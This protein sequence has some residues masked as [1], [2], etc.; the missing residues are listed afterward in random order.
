MGWKDLK[1]GK[2]LAFGF[3]TILILFAVASFLNYNNLTTVSDEMQ[4]S[5][6]ANA[7]KAFSIEK[8]VDHLNWVIGLREIFLN[9]DVR[10]VQ[11]QMDPTQCGLGKWLLSD[12]TKQ[13]AAN[14]P[15]LAQLLKEIEAPHRHL[16]ESAKTIDQ[17]YKNDDVAEAYEVF[18]KETN[19]HLSQTK[20]ILSQLKDHFSDQSKHAEAEMVGQVNSSITMMTAITIVGIIIGALAAY[21]IT[22]GIARPIGRISDVA[23]EIAMGEINHEIEVRSKD[24]VG[25][26]AHAFQN[27]IGYMRNIAQGAEKI[28]NNDLRVE[29]TPKSEND[30]LGNSFKTMSTNLRNIISQLNAGSGELVAAAN[31]IASTSAEMAKGAR[32]QTEQATQIA[33]AIEEMAA[34]IVQSSQNANTAKEISE[35][36]SKTANEGQGIVQNTVSGMINIAGAAGESTTIVSELAQAADRIG[37]IISVIDDIADQTNLLA[38]NAAIEAARAG[39]QGRG[40]AVVADEV[41]KL[42][43]RTGKATGEITEMI[44]GIQ[45]DSTRA[46]ESMENASKLVSEGQELADKAGNS[47]Q[48]INSMS[49][50][51]MD[52]IVQIATASD[53]Q[54]AAAE[55]IS[56]NM[57]YIS[58][59]TRQT[60]AGAE[61]SASA[62]EELN[63]QAESMREMVSMFKL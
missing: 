43:E 60:S 41:R 5:R 54:S 13:L 49:S 2:K 51:V 53:Q 7:N 42:A 48:E 16:H 24:E 21:V 58:S 17:L 27:L 59:I 61:Q 8:E 62:A 46:V 30:I 55:Q 11:V 38:L 36:S 18:K 28:A 19:N 56:K 14:D 12:E 4:V 10:S 3:G 25:M 39:E 63:R 52:M 32:N 44:N 50:R 26:L 29:I 1:I 23:N 57:E 15:E 45:R 31:E 22:R 9:D 6:E 47:L 33:S 20:H 37:E 34:T 35:D 40:F